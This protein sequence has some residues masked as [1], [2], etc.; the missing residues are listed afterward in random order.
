MRDEASSAR[1]C[2]SLPESPRLAKA[3]SRPRCRS[4]VRA[5]KASTGLATA[6][7]LPTPGGWAS[8]APEGAVWLPAG[9]L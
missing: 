3:F 6:A 4:A 2:P 1:N 5:K 9:G 7:G 8:L